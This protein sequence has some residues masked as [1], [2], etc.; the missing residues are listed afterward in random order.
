MDLDDPSW[1][2]RLC[3]A[4]A[5]E[6]ERCRGNRVMCLNCCSLTSNE[7]VQLPS[8][9]VRVTARC[10]MDKVCVTGQETLFNF[11]ACVCVQ[12]IRASSKE[13]TR[14]AWAMLLSTSSTGDCRTLSCL[15]PH[16]SC[17]LL[18]SLSS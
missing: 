1:L 2:D 9:D 10:A 13:Q 6:A 17:S 5:C 3:V 14:P 12:L 8:L 7:Q 16:R 15:C 11:E 4:D 18:Q